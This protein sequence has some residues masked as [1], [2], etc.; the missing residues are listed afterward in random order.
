MAVLRVPDKN[1]PR[2][3]GHEIRRF[4]DER[5]TFYEH[6]STDVGL[7]ADATDDQVLAAYNPGS[8]R[9]WTKADTAPLTSCV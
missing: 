8:S 5:G 1:A 6:W 9:S 3:G 4:P 7:P 2:A